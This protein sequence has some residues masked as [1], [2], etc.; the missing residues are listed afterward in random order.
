MIK[1]L[2]CI[3]V[4]V[5]AMALPSQAMDCGQPPIVAP[6]VPDGATASTADIRAAR[7]DV[8][9]YSNEVDTYIS[10]MDQAG[11]KVAPYLTKEQIARRQDD[12]NA[13]HDDRRDLQLALNEAI[14][15]FRRQGDN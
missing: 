6:S 1:N 8:L 9:A 11:L 4:A 14:R 5:V 12:L 3:L 2:G 13:L 7:D 10:C 15:A